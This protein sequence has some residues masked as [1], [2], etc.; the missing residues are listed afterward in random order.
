MVGR[1]WGGGVGWWAGGNARGEQGGG[2]RADVGLWRRV[3]WRAVALRRR[4][5]RWRW[6]A[7]ASV[8]VVVEVLLCS[9][10][11]SHLEIPKGEEGDYKPPKIDVDCNLQCFSQHCNH[12]TGVC[13]GSPCFLTKRRGCLLLR[14]GGC[15]AIA[16]CRSPARQEG[17]QCSSGAVA[18]RRGATLAPKRP[19]FYSRFL[20]RPVC[21]AHRGL[22]TLALAA[23]RRTTP[24]R[25]DTRGSLAE[26]TA[27]MRVVARRSLPSRTR[28][29]ETRAGPDSRVCA[30]RGLVSVQ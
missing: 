28:S 9:A 18:T 30:P 21:G 19:L 11:S 13:L 8:V 2:R 25:H 3:G 29:R 24:P 20:L 12:H 14:G 26:H 10:T 27:S 22:Q 15:A 4:R 5:R 6:P 1:R 23:R 7:E 17:V 16:S